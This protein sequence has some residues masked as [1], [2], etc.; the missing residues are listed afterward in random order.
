MLFDTQIE[1]LQLAI[2]ID[3]NQAEEFGFHFGKWRTGNISEKPSRVRET[4]D[5]PLH[6][7]HLLRH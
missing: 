4:N 5:G 3:S 7:I 1:P 6:K 2:I